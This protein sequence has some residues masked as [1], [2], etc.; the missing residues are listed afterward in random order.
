MLL[1]LPPPFSSTK[2]RGSGCVTVLVLPHL[3][4]TI[5]TWIQGMLRVRGSETLSAAEDSVES[6]SL[7][8]ERVR[9]V[10]EGALH[11]VTIRHPSQTR[12]L[13]ICTRDPCLPGP[14]MT[15][16]LHIVI[17]RSMSLAMICRMLREFAGPSLTGTKGAPTLSAHHQMAAWH[18]QPTGL[19]HPVPLERW[20]LQYYHGSLQAF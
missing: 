4:S 3:A 19:S 9:G 16:H 1:A 15:R 10:V 6:G 17:L 20:P 18:F 8:V 12:T 11:D 13:C 7:A 14:P 5:T 2:P